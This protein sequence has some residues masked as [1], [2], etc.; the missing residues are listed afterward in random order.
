MMKKKFKKI[1]IKLKEN[2]VEILG[3]SVIIVG[4]ILFAVF[5][6]SYCDQAME[7]FINAYK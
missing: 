5:T 6:F 7:N 1:A 4:L 3:C 2:W